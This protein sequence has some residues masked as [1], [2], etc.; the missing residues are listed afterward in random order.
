MRAISRTTQFKRDAKRMKK[1]GKAFGDF[2]ETIR[3]LA[4][5]EELAPKYRDHA[6]VGQYVGTRECHV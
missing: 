1:R 3:S 2:L 6:L 4:A 5:G